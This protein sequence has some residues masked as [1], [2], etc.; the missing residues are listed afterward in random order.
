MRIWS[1]ERGTTTLAVTAAAGFGLAVFVLLAN[2]VLLH[3]ARGVA[4]TAVD[5]AVRQATVMESACIH[6]AESVLSDLLGGEYGA[7]LEARCEVTDGT[8]HA[9][10]FGTVPSLIPGVPGHSLEASA[11]LVLADG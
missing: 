7:G 3:Y 9:V 4:R 8:L 2:L 11:S 10:V 5:E 6:T 1:D